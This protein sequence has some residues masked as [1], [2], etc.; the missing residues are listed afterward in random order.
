MRRS[1]Q[2]L[3]MLSFNLNS[4][5]FFVSKNVGTRVFI[6]KWRGTHKPHLFVSA[7]LSVYERPGSSVFE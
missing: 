5:L 4:H 1:I 6:V 3:M 7:M 2:Q